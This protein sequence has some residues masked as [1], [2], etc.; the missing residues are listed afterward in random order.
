[1]GHRYVMNL[2]E[3]LFY[4]PRKICLW[5]LYGIKSR[6]T[7]KIII[8]LSVEALLQGNISQEWSWEGHTAL[9]QY[10]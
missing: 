3:W 10:K 5:L 2:T 9:V 6:C 4:G 1:M 7:I 8:Y